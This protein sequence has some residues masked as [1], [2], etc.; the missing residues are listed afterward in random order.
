MV[1]KCKR[2]DK[3]ARKARGIA[4]AAAQAAEAGPKPLVPAR[5]LKALKKV[6]SKVEANIED[7]AELRKC[8]KKI[9]AFLRYVENLK[10]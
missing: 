5:E 4:K 3:Q 10:K 8:E 7:E 1:S 2:A 6:L 9:K